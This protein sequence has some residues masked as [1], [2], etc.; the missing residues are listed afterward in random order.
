MRKLFP[1]FLIVALVVPSSFPGLP[2]LS[3]GA[4]EQRSMGELSSAPRH[5]RTLAPLHPSPSSPPPPSGLY[6]TRVAVRQPFDWTRLETW[7]IV[8]LERGDDWALV[9]VDE[10]QLETLARLRFEPQST[11]E[12]GMLVAA[13]AEA[14]PWLASSLQPLLDQAAVAHS[15][16]EAEGA[17]VTEALAGVRASLRTLTPEQIAGIAALSSVDDDGD[18]LSNT[19][20]AWWCTDPMNSDSDG[21]LVSDGEEVQA[22]KDWL[23]NRLPG[24]PHTAKPFAGWPPQTDSAGYPDR[25]FACQDDDQDSVPDLAEARELGLKYGVDKE[26]PRLTMNRESTDRD[27][28][29]DGQ[30]LFGITKCPGYGALPRSVDEGIIFCEMP[31]WVEPPGDH[32][33]VAA[34]PVPE[35]DVVESSLHVETVTEIKNEHT[36]LTGTERSYSTAKTEG[37]STSV[38]EGVTWNDWQEISTTRPIEERA[39]DGRRWS[40]EVGAHVPAGG[41][42]LLAGLSF[43]S[44]VVEEAIDC[45]FDFL[46]DG[47]SRCG[48][49][50]DNRYEI[51]ESL[52]SAFEDTVWDPN[53]DL[54]QNT[55]KIG[56]C[57]DPVLGP[58]GCALKAGSA[59]MKDY[60]TRLRNKSDTDPDSRS[61]R[62]GGGNMVSYD[63]T[64]GT[65]GVQPV[66]QFSYAAPRQLPTETQ[67]TGRS[68]GGSQATTQEEYEEHT[69]TNGEAFL[70]VCRRNRRECGWNCQ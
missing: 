29:D 22:L 62:G 66:F 64:A 59:F 57:Y 31:A 2:V 45:S 24:P 7:G 27:K 55:L 58:A 67:S 32:P 48:Q 15:R 6:R 39:E 34:Y 53:Q 3:M 5:T 36:I 54:W 69:V 21:D 13:H 17:S 14:K 9:L 38:T 63:A 40:A 37:T 61:T 25:H 41:G 19:Q 35:I 60:G 12:L 46:A 30:E 16:V 68:W 18:G 1:L 28:F 51:R 56:K 23:S 4:E 11:D 65:V 42:S 10:D 8:V 52:V 20:E 43:G 49:I 44:V 26:I 50:Y 47:T 33:V 70:A